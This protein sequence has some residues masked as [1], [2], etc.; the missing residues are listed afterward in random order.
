MPTKARPQSDL[1][2]SNVARPSPHVD[3]ERFRADLREGGVEEMVGALLAT[4]AQDSPERFA[5]LEQAVQQG[6]TKA[7]EGAAHAFKS[8]A[9][10]IRAT[11]LATMLSDIEVAARAAKLDSVPALLEQIR[12]EYV[13]VLRELEAATQE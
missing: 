1:K 6:N 8:G 12:E 9:G 5:A 13:A 2:I 4:F 10:T 7:I 11:G 3:L